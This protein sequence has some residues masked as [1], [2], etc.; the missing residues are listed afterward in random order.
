MER[1]GSDAAPMDD[2]AVAPDESEGWANL[3]GIRVTTV[4]AQTVSS[5]KEDVASVAESET[6]LVGK[7]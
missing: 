2:K 7:V 1:L 6:K 4:V 5:G 3:S